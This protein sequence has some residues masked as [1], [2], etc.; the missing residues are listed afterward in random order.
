MTRSILL[1]L[2]AVAGLTAGFG[3]IAAGAAPVSYTLPDETA[4]FKP[5][6]KPSLALSAVSSRT[7]SL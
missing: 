7:F 6:T 1:A 5:G 2:T 3:L 4:A